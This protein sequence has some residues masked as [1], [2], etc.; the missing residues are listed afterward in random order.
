MIPK[1][2]EMTS[3][4]GG[5]YLSA[6][7]FQI[8]KVT[9]ARRGD[10]GMAEAKAWG[11]L[12]VV[13]SRLASLDPALVGLQQP[14]LECYARNLSIARE[15]G[16]PQSVGVALTNLGSAFAKSGNLNK[17]AE[18]ATEGLGIWRNLGNQDG[19]FRQLQYLGHIYIKLEDW[20]QAIECF[21]ASMKLGADLGSARLF[22][23]ARCSLGETHL[24]MGQLSQAEGYF[25]ESLNT[26]TDPRDVDFR[27]RV[28]AFLRWIELKKEIGE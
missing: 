8:D 10:D 4:Q 14:E 18:L 11:N 9:N 16:D 2:T 26:T 28:A 19:E 23:I 27:T 21:Q 17:A 20:R 6:I 3:A 1:I 22:M 7:A 5:E 15:Y 12:G 24:A 25:R 13:F